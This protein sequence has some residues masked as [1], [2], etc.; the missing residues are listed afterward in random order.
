V[1][2]DESNAKLLAAPP[3]GER[4]I[5]SGPMLLARQVR[6]VRLAV[7]FGRRV[8]VDRL[9]VRAEKDPPV[10]AANLGL[11]RADGGRVEV[12]PVVAVDG[13]APRC[14]SVAKRCH[15]DSRHQERQVKK[16]RNKQ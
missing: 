8:L 14:L 5:V 6:A 7:P 2:C 13:D 1:E 16:A 10:A 3:S 12:D 9:A 4:E 11:V 15:E